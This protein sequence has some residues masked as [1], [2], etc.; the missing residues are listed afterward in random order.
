MTTAT[1]ERRLVPPCQL[2]V[3]DEVWIDNPLPSEEGYR[4]VV[5][6]VRELRGGW[7]RVW[8][9]VYE[10]CERRSSALAGWVTLQGYPREC[11][12]W[13]RLYG[14]WAGADIDLLEV[15]T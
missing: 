10:G 14:V 2:E 7:V 1:A 15:V 3:G 5:A 4:H 9:E 6:D 13:D 12:Q 8:F 11:F